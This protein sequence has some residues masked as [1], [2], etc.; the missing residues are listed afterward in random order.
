[1]SNPIQPEHWFYVGW[2]YVAYGTI[3]LGLLL[4]GEHGGERNVV[5]IFFRRISWSL[6]RATGYPG[7][8]MAGAL[9]ALHG[10]GVAVVGLYWDVAFHIDYG[11]DQDLFTPSHTMIVL[12]LQGLVL[13]AVLAVIFAT[14]DEAPSRFRVGS[15]RVPFSAVM[16][17]ALGIGGLAGFPL[18]E[19]WHRA[20]GVDVTLWSPTHLQLVAGGALSPIAVWLMLREGHHQFAR[21]GGP[22]PTLLGRGIVVLALGAVLTGLGAFMGE[23]DFGVPQFQV[24]YL[25]VLVAVVS[26]FALVL[27]RLALGPGGALMTAGVF[28]ALRLLLGL[29]VSGA[30]N[31]TYPRFPLFLA[32]AV[33]VELVAWAVGTERALRFAAVAG[34]AVGT[35]GVAAEMVWVAAS[36]WFPGPPRP[37]PLVTYALVPTAAVAAAIIATAFGGR[38]TV[39]ARLPTGAVAAAG[40]ALVVALAVPLPRQ[41]GDIDG[42]V[43]LRPGGTGEAVVEVRVEPIDAVDGA[44]AFAVTA[45]QGGGRVHAGLR[46]LGPGRFES[47]EPV[48]VTGSWKTVVSLQRGNEVMAAPVYLPADPEI[49]APAIPALPER[50]VEFVRNT[51]LLLREVHGG[52]AWPAVVGYGGVATVLAGWMLLFTRCALGLDGAR[53]G[54][55]VAPPGGAPRRGPPPSTGRVVPTAVADDDDDDLR[56]R[57]REAITAGR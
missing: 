22:G 14:N 43:T 16:L 34:A 28:V 8:A 46:E 37:L 55:A 56:R 6:E 21:A 36:D 9:T 24:G 3:V 2:P 7:W 50:Q 18:D 39:G 32:G 15:L 41:D 33:A 11:R 13:A 47:T 30:L 17:A 52:P 25:P 38:V 4:A 42:V 29:V 20:Y 35:A 49:G 23:F 31:H 26:G 45:W 1:M 44:N 5:R 10:L 12:G 51:E 48:P 19:L 57:W 53:A 54:A 40:V 27:G